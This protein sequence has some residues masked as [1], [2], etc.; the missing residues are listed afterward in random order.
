MI[1]VTVEYISLHSNKKMALARRRPSDVGAFRHL[2]FHRHQRYQISISIRQ[3]NIN[4]IISI[5]NIISISNS[6]ISI[7]NIIIISNSN[8][9][10]M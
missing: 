7:S 4:S 1:L 8:I 2:L 9:N 3:S 6:N 5:N 10:S